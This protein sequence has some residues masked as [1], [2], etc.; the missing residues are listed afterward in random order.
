MDVQ[1]DRYTFGLG[2][3]EPVQGDV[4]AGIAHDRVDRLGPIHVEISPTTVRPF[5]GAARLPLSAVHHTCQPSG[6]RA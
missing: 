2:A 5:Y 6:V 3:G 1:P 4:N